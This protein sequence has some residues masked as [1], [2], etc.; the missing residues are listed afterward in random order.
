MNTRQALRKLAAEARSRALH[1]DARAGK[2][3]AR[4]HPKAGERDRARKKAEAYRAAA[5]LVD[6]LA[7]ET[8]EPAPV[9][10]VSNV[11]PFPIQYRSPEERSRFNAAVTWILAELGGAAELGAMQAHAEA[12]LANPRDAI[13]RDW[14]A[15]FLE[16][17]KESYG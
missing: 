6:Q 5:E 7:A 11:I 3:P 10:D 14:S 13:H 8:P 4:A 17:T 12:E 9:P 2:D 1:E 16:E 15:T